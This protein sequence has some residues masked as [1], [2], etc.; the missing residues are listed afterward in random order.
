[1]HFGT[2]PYYSTLPHVRHGYGLVA[3]G[4]TGAG[5][6]KIFSRSQKSVLGA[7]ACENGVYGVDFSNDSGLL[8]I[9]GGDSSIRI[10]GVPRV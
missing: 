7:I 2:R 10:V 6:V 8:A 3:A 1:M 5:E 4:G 9:A